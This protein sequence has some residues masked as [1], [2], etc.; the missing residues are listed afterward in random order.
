MLLE[1]FRFE[2]H[3]RLRRISTYVYALVFFTL[4]FLFVYIGGGAINGASMDFGTG[5]KVMINSPFALGFIITY[6]SLFGVIMTAAMAG[7]ATYQD[8]DSRST[9]L[10]YTAPI[11]KFGYLGGRFLG[12]IAIQVVIF[13]AIGLGAWLGA[14]GPGVDPTRI[15]PD[16]LDAY[17][18]PYVILVL[19][20]LILTSAI[21]FG[22]AALGR[23]ML[24]VYTGSVLLL[25]GY[26]VATQLASNV[27]VTVL[28]AMA[29]PFGSN[30]FGRATQYWT[31][32]ES[33][34]LS[35]PLGGIVLANRVLWLAVAIG[36]FVF[37][38]LRFSMI[39]HAQAGKRRLRT[40]TPEEASGP[41]V[42]NLPPAHR[43]FSFTGSLG[44]LASL[45][46]LQ[47]TETVKNVFFAVIVL[48]GFGFA[49]VA[50]SGITDPFATPV[51]P[52]TYRMLGYAGG[53]FS[54][55]ALIIITF[56]AG[57]LVWRER[58]AQLNQ[59]VDALPV[60]RWVLFGSK[61]MALMLVQVLLMLVV[62]VAGL[63]I[64][65]A[66]GYHHFELGLYFKEL[67]V[68]QLTHYW[69]L[70]VLALSIHTV[71][72][73]KYLGHFIM[74]LYY[75]AGIA[76]PALGVQHYLVRLDYIPTLI[77]SDM[78]G[79]GPFRAPLFWFHLYWGLAAVAIAI[80]TN[81]LWV[82]GVDT[83]W[84]GRLKLA[85]A[86]LG[87][88]S[89]MG[90]TAS[91]LLFVGAG[92]YIFYNTN[93]LNIYRSTYAVDDARAQ[94]EKKYRQ[95][96]TMPGPKITDVTIQIDLDPE[97]LAAAIR[98][99]M[100]LE[101]KTGAPLEQ[102]AVTIWPSD[103]QPLPRPHIG[104]ERLTVAEGQIPVIEDNDLGF[105]LYRLPQPLAPNAKLTLDFALNYRCDGFVNS[106]P[107]VNILNNGSFL[108]NGYLPTIGYSQGIELIDDSTRHRHGL[109]RMSRLPKLEDV[110]ARQI[111]GVGPDA[112]WVNLDETV[113]TSSD[114]IAIM[115]GY[116]QK[117]WTEGGRHYFHY[118]MDAPILNIYS[119]N[120]GRYLVQRDKWNNVNLEIYYQPGH[121][122]NLD[123][124]Q[125]SM[126]SALDYCSANFSPY[127]F[128]QLRIMEFPRYQTFAE[129]FANTIP[130]S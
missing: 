55:F 49:L 120:S 60:K 101:N 94:Y 79:F 53:A 103:L 34:T 91:L 4:A 62:M 2:I 122:F 73:Q 115:P 7:Q 69:I 28:A 108:S 96:L 114:Q 90:V 41:V 104:M 85:T 118:K 76:L 46:A 88:A 81:L 80:V 12:A 44:Q 17:V 109:E 18:R 64:Q 130:F 5:G 87:P 97:R 42:L 110:A 128:R 10:F 84:R 65:I 33:N 13:A 95:Y 15:G 102:V 86:R 58:D 67:F 27:N 106:N 74:V 36:V 22:V 125:D 83:G 37:T 71:V 51:Y 29:D 129:S 70:C 68:D 32:F 126:K 23:K 47:F 107:N 14:H 63:I 9:E 50:A 25:I 1:I 99:T 78:N 92:A 113:S 61:L 26:L 16:R 45:G 52:V 8:V 123:R 82:R 24:P 48:A 31:P 116:L 35:L 20:N 54:L 3:E 75:I 66:F 121:E 40:E 30:A 105:Y 39:H 119:L 111:N 117:E 98:G 56:Y 112:D 21:F 59:I 43:T 11:T 77:Y 19:P 38:Y 57:D 6:V 72:N 89:R 124:M 93:V 127:Q 100:Q